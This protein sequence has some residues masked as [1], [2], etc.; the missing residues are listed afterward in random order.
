MDWT[1][2]YVNLG[3][4]MAENGKNDSLTPSQRRALAALLEQR[5]M[6]SAAAA[7][8]VGERT[9]HRWIREEPFASALQQAQDELFSQVLRRL[10]H[11]SSY[12]LDALERSL[13]DGD[14]PQQV[15]AADIILGKL[16][17]AREL[18]ELEP[19]LRA[20]ENSITVEY[21]NDWRSLPE[22]QK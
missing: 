16:L 2:R 1:N 21:V 22:E 13:R 12:A 9:L 7:A 17:K 3:G 8:C 20:L 19:R 6:R 5:D 10:S 11:A 18:L 15:R 14:I 4:K